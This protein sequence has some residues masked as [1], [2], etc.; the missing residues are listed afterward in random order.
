MNGMNKKKKLLSC[1]KSLVHSK[2]TLHRELV[3]R[4]ADLFQGHIDTSY[5]STYTLILISHKS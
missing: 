1:F 4:C 3:P 5:N 2:E